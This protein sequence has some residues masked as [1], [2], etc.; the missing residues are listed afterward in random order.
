MAKVKDQIRD[1]STVSYIDA[2][3]RICYN[4][5]LFRHIMPDAYPL[6]S[7]N[8]TGVARKSSRGY[9]QSQQG[10][11]S[12]L[13]RPR[14][15]CFKQCADR[16]NALPDECPDPAPCPPRSSKASVWEAKQEQGVMCSY[17]DLYMSCCLKSCT[18]ISIVGPDG[19]G[20]TGGAISADDDCWPCE[21]PCKTSILSIAYTSQ[22]MQV[23]ES[24]A[25]HAHDSEYGDEV[26]C[27][28]P[29]ELRWE[30][31][32]GGGYLNP[33]TGPSV[34]YFAAASNPGCAS[35][36]LIKLS[37]CCGREATLAIAVNSFTDPVALAYSMIDS[38]RDIA[39]VDNCQLAF[40]WIYG[41]A[42]I[43]NAWN[44]AGTLLEREGLE[45]CNGS[46][47]LSSMAG[48]C[49]LETPCGPMPPHTCDMIIELAET[50]CPSG[51]HRT[52]EM[53]EQGCCPE[54]A[55]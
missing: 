34:T 15:E 28:Q 13:Q 8:P 5:E 51:D 23:N 12:R 45:V 4:D 17:L 30:I 52:P 35:N 50:V 3:G 7:L 14:R 11:G 44:C 36:A 42:G 39:P 6:P 21:P 29:D 38:C 47:D 32:T 53:I 41:I 18:E 2:A 19:A 24:Q 22:Q 16:W 40:H 55:L 37:D 26:P 43:Y 49:C 46:G 25:L 9:K 48:A 27:C 31:V 54:Q 20:Y 33:S 10:N 1:R